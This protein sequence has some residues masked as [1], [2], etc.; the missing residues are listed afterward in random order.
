MINDD[1]EWPEH[2]HFDFDQMVSNVYSGNVTK[3]A[4][5]KP[6]MGPWALGVDILPMETDHSGIIHFYVLKSQCSEL[7][8]AV[9]NYLYIYA[10]NWHMK[11]LIFCH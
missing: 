8:A 3:G 4:L 10:S 9:I 6:Y 11:K 5:I 2:N 7:Q 1:S